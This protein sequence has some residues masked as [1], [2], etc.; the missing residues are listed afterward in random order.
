VGKVVFVKFLE[1][2][3]GL[4]SFVPALMAVGGC[5]VS[6]L[7]PTRHPALHWLGVLLPLILL[8]N[9]LVMLFWIWKRSIWMMVPIA[10]ILICIP[11]ITSMFH[12]PLRKPAPP[13]KEVT[14]ATYNIHN[15]K[16]E[17]DFL[18]GQQFARFVEVESVDIICLQEFPI[19]GV[20]R[21]G[22]IQELSKLL[23]YYQISS[24]QPG[25]MNMAIFSRY[26]I[27]E[28]QPVIFVDET[29]N[30][31][32]WVDLDL[33]GQ[34][35]RVFNNHLQTTNINQYKLPL[36]QGLRHTVAQMKKL[37]RVMEENGSIRTRQADV[38]RG[39]LDES[40]YPLIVCGDFNAN[41]ASYTYRTIK[42][43]LRDSFREVGKGYGYSYRYLKK[44]YRIDY[45]FYSPDSFRAIHY[46]S[47]DLA[48][49]DHKPVVVTF[50]FTVGD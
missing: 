21:L 39:L 23:P 33:E 20:V 49:S 11:F 40:P 15:Q 34:R 29:D 5:Y 46:H 47:P 18:D 8:F 30:F 31:S 19:T 17:N 12:W 9:V 44:L 28:M 10:A 13:E 27:I 6:Y 24:R 38:I 26:P 37:K 41:P 48:F 35:V 32:F 3:L 16:G 25:A 1:F 43:K 50:D 14:V 45:I 22:L 4:L 42:G 36:T 7:H 2:L